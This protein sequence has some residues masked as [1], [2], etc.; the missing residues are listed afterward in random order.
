[1]NLNRRTL[2]I[3]LSTVYA[4]SAMPVWAQ[5]TSVPVP[6]V[7]L[8]EGRNFQVLKT[9]QETG[10]PAGKIEILEFF[11]YGCPHCNTIDQPLA[12]WLK[13]QGSDVVLR[14]SHID[15]GERTE[16]HQRLFYT[17][18]ALGELSKQHL[19]VFTAIHG[20]KKALANKAQVLEWAKSRGLDMGKF[21]AAYSSFSMATTL[22]RSKQMMADFKVEGVPHFAVDGRF[23]TSPSIAGGSPANFFGVMESLIAKVRAERKPDA[24][25][26]KPAKPAKSAAKPAKAPTTDA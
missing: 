24:K 14:R 16:A 7:P 8:Q 5:A 3:A 4:S 11:W 2:A 9:R 10:V 17:L 21:E 13:K 25:S 6:A 20:D 18:E 12:D 26:A 19:A 15:F 1:M 23:I 22:N